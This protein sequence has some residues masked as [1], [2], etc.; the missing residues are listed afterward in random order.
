MKVKFFLAAFLVFAG[1]MVYSQLNSNVYV[2]DTVTKLPVPFVSIQFVDTNIGMY[3]ND[4]GFFSRPT[5]KKI[6]LSCV[7][8]FS[9]LLELDNST[10]TLFMLPQIYNL[11]E[12]V[13][14]P[15]KNKKT[16]MLGYFNA[17]HSFSYSQSSGKELAVFIANVQGKDFLLKDVV[18]RIDR[19]KVVLRDFD[20]VSVFKLN[21]YRSGTRKEIG[22]LINT[23][24]L[25]YSSEILEK[26]TII[27]LSDLNIIV[28]KDG[29]YIGIEWVGTL[30]RPSSE[31]YI[32][33]KNS[34]EPFIS[35][36]FDITNSFVYERNTWGDNK[37]I[38][39]DK[40]HVYSKLAGKSNGFTPCI[41]IVG[42]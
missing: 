21:I 34:I 7:G 10:D 5:E 23:K 24:D 33:S 17:K 9:K 29:I 38:L 16:I 36:T 37:W 2:V 12:V 1:N 27:N 15:V 20:F 18:L 35:G 6:Q 22:S 39:F 28:P 25:I 30:R 11:P 14:S 3:T 40:G 26:K 32:E 4:L 31:L 42:Y 41:S 19:R 8:Y 13:I